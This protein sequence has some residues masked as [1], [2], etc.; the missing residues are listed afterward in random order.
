MCMLTA[1]I[2]KLLFK[3]IYFFSL[4]YIRMSRKNINLD[5][6]KKSEKANFTKTEK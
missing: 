1:R 6:K 5:A 3:K 2:P 4:V